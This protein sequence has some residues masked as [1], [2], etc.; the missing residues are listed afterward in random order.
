MGDLTPAPVSRA[1]A[2]NEGTEQD[3]GAGQCRAGEGAD[4]RALQ[5]TG[6]LGPRG[7][8]RGKAGGGRMTVSPTLIV[9]FRFHSF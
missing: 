1:W 4:S 9:P 8:C 3:W 7:S 2:L 5:V 6:W